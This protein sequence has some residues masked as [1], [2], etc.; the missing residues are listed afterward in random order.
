MPQDAWS[1]KR[2][3]Q[4]KH[5]KEEEK[6]SGRSEGTAERIAAATVNRTRTAKGETKEPKSAVE[7]SKAQK[8]AKTASKRAGAKSR[9]GT[10]KKTTARTRS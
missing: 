7:R 8:A 4:Y 9:G 5:I 10:R 2:E 1:P 3:R 6:K